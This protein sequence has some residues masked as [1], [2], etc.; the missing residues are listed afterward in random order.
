MRLLVIL[1]LLCGTAKAQQAEILIKNG[2]ILDGTG[3][4]WYYG[5][6]AIS[7]GKIV[8]IGNLGKW[9]ANRVIDARQQW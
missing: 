6:I 3:N 9:T 5:D 8:R 4:S 1:L 7:N 2:R